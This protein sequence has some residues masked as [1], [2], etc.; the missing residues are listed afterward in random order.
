MKICDFCQQNG[1]G[2]RPATAMLTMQSFDGIE[3]FDVCESCVA[4]VRDLL[5]QPKEEKKIGPGRPRK[6]A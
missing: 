5:T 6:A 4:I 3:T 2:F 1:D